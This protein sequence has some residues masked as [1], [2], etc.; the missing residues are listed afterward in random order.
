MGFFLKEKKDN[1]INFPYQDIGCE[2]LCCHHRAVYNCMKSSTQRLTL[3]ALPL[4]SKDKGVSFSWP[5]MCVWLL[6]GEWLLILCSPT[7]WKFIMSTCP[8]LFVPMG[9]SFPSSNLGD[10]FVVSVLPVISVFLHVC[11]PP[12]FWHV[13][14]SVWFVTFLQCRVVCHIV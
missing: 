5:I 12:R 8:R 2:T 13:G 6:S 10:I 4:Y 14:V 7:W 9:A 1:Q 3:S 11:P